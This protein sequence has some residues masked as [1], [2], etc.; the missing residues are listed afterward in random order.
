MRKTI[1]ATLAIMCL[2]TSVMAE[3]KH[4]Q[5]EAHIHGAGELKIA[6]EGGRVDLELEIPGMDIVGFEH[7]A[8]TR[9]QRNAIKAA[10]KMLHYNVMSLFVLSSEAKCELIS[11][12]VEVPGHEEDVGKEHE[13][14]E[15]DE[16]HSEFHAKYRLDCASIE[17]LTSI[18]F[19][20]F[21]YFPLSKSLDVKIITA[22]S[23]VVKRVTRQKPLLA[24]IGK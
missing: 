21:D 8:S 17:K 23:Q 20:F 16:E 12:N 4:R 11:S 10:D 3:E 2:G 1:S 7:E 5:L 19:A 13:E 6:I 15:R 9:P 18:K 22:N 24:M 14:E